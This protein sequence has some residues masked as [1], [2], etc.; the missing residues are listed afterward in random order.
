MGH[1]VSGTASTAEEAI[2]R[3]S[4]AD[5]V[6]MDIHIDGQRDGIEAATE[7][8]SR[9][10]LPVVFLTAH[11][12][13]S[14]LDRAKLAGP[15][16]YIVKP[17]GPA[18]LQTGIE[19]A[20]ARHRVER[21]LEERE[22]WLRQTIACLADGVVVTTAEG[23]V[24]LLNPAAERLTGWN[25]TEAEGLSISQV[26]RLTDADASEGDADFISVALLRD[27]PVDL[28]PR[29]H[30]SSRD[31]RE[32]E[33]EGSVAPVR[34]SQELLGA[35]MTFRD[36]SARHWEERQ[37]RQAQRLEAAGRLAASAANEYTTAIATIRKQTENLLLRFSEYSPARSALEEIHQSA[38]AADRITR[39][40][41]LFGTRQVG[42]PEVLSVN[43]LLRRMSRLIESA[44]GDR[45]QMALR[46]S[47]GA[48]RI[49][50]DMAQM[51]SAV[52]NLITHASRDHVQEG[53]ADRF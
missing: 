34:L 29:C 53:R 13:R 12:D 15:F 51:E 21:L 5:I 24:R 1:E 30:L 37:L 48:G 14:T 39:R 10:R 26:V 27:A 38:A 16:G 45:I 43:S 11:A 41:A 7:I 25:Q 50:A 28:P 46:L 52:M 33:I 8:R 19:M 44:A 20:I 32:M 6:L 4:S 3:A 36:A 49:R 31:G 40:L 23:R 22:M 42:Q 9:H 18:S 17:L 2:D 35:V 47:P